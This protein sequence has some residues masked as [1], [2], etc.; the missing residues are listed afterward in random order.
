MVLQRGSLSDPRSVPAHQRDGWT[1][2]PATGLDYRPAT[3]K[4]QME[5]EPAI[6]HNGQLSALLEHEHVSSGGGNTCVSALRA[7]L[8]LQSKL[9][10]SRSFPEEQA[11]G[12][13]TIGQT[14]F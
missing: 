13:Q 1:C 9:F 11:E 7:P 3:G 12:V 14:T 8:R 5:A 2:G 4:V 6:M 10:A